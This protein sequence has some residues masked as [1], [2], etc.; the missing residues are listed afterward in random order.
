MPRRQAGSGEA[1]S[2]G[3]TRVDEEASRPANRP[4]EVDELLQDKR[5]MLLPSKPLEGLEGNEGV[6]RSAQEYAALE[7][8]AGLIRAGAVLPEA[9]NELTSRGDSTGELNDA[10][11]IGMESLSG[12]VCGRAGSASAAEELLRECCDAG[13][14]KARIEPRLSRSRQK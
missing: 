3:I 13:L 2:C 4:Q 12:V 14:G 7:A 6:D 8:R 9:L 5:S 11:S 10:L 1:A